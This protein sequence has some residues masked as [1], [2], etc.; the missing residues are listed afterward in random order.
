[1]PGLHGV[2]AVKNLSAV[3]ETQAWS[4]GQEGALL[5]GLFLTQG[6]NP[7]LLCLLHCRCILYCWA[8]RE[9]LY[10]GV[11]SLPLLQ[12]I[13]PTQEQNRGLLH[14]R[15]ILYHL[16]CQGRQISLETQELDITHYQQPKVRNLQWFFRVRERMILPSPTVLHSLLCSMSKLVT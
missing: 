15:Q 14:C 8:T 16:S 12:Q 4:L 9:A 10:I 1:M 6:W 11:S 5:Q 13:F 7:H 2:S 3:Q